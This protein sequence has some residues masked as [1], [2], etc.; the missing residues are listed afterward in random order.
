MISEKEWYSLQDPR[1]EF[2]QNEVLRGTNTRSQRKFSKFEDMA[3][4]QDAPTLTWHPW[5]LG[6]GFLEEY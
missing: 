1:L 5:S 4:Q 3:R 6:E 2:P